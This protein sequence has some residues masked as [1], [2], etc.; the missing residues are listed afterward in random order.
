MN[1]GYTVPL[2]LTHEYP[3]EYYG[4]PGTYGTNTFSFT[5]WLKRERRQSTFLK[6]EDARLFNLELCPVEGDGLKGCLM[7]D[8]RFDGPHTLADTLVFFEPY[9][10]TIYKLADYL[11]AQ[12]MY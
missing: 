1:G 3:V 10:D 11:Q 2:E 12:Q 5:M 4:K 6:V 7:A 9:W 8:F